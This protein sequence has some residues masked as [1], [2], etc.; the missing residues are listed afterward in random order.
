MSIVPDLRAVLIV[1][2]A[3]RCRS[4]MAAAFLLKA[5]T[6]RSNVAN[7]RINSAGTWAEPGLPATSLA[8]TIMAER[9]L[10]ISQ[11]RARI[12]DAI[13][14][15]TADVILVMTK[16]HLEALQAEFPKVSGKIFLLSQLVGQ[17]YDIKD[18]FGGTRE[19]YQRCA[20]ELEHL[21]NDGFVR[22]VEWTDRKAVN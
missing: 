2:T 12:I 20:A 15:R 5:I 3:N 17:V 13:M 1:C 16:N 19:D 4:P 11:H 9:G 18:P 14:L 21:V 10:D 6:E 22:L 8:Q 7:W